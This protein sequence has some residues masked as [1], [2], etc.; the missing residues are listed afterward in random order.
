MKFKKLVSNN[1]ELI[2]I[3]LLQRNA[4]TIVGI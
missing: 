2:N 1:Y 4:L 3:I